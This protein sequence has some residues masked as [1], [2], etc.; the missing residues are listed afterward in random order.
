MTPGKAIRSVCVAC[1]GSAHEVRDC[2]GNDCLNGQGDEGGV[3]YFYQ[4]RM[5][6]GRASV[7]LIRKFCLECMN[8]S[9][10]L[11]RECPSL[12]CP[13]HQYRFGKNPKRAGVGNKRPITPSV[14]SVNETQN[15]IR[16]SQ[17]K[18]VMTPWFS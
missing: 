9:K 15:L 17:R 8:G 6:R 1:V 12:L 10:R 14:S 2:R 11:V 16:V 5:G 3:C 18:E 13:L 7:K 4:Y